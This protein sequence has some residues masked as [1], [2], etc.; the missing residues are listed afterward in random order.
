M[1]DTID[2]ANMGM[3]VPIVGQDPGPQWA[4]D[5][6]TC[7]GIIDAHTH[8]PGSGVQITPDGL[9]INTDLTFNSNNQLAIKSSRYTSQASPLGGGADLDCLYVVQGDL[10]YNDGAGN[11]VQITSGGAVAGTPGSISNLV[12]PASA[13]YNSGTGTFIW[14]SN[15]NVAANMDM[16][17]ITIREQVASANGITI[18]SPA[19]LGANYTLTLPAALPASVKFLTVDNAGNI[20]DVLYVDNSTIDI[21]SNNI[22]VAPSG[23]TATQLASNSVTT[24]KIADG[25]V[26]RPKLVSVG[27]Q[28]SAS[29]GLYQPFAYTGTYDQI[30]NLSC[31]ITTTGRPVFIGLQSEGN[32]SAGAYAAFGSPQTY[33]FRVSR[34]STVIGQFVIQNVFES[35]VR[36]TF[37]QLPGFLKLDN[38][39]AGTYTYTLK[40]FTALNNS[41]F[42]E[43]NEYQLV[44]YEL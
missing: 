14:E 22:R 19:S 40:Q 21:N 26:T 2:S 25:N 10:Y 9:N 30:T 24:A 5:V 36:T 6:N 41:Q 23:I 43:L 37:I 44:V 17:S 39:S 38:P 29:C 27:Q 18:S 32:A 34:D 8:S 3:P 1:A 16:A 31:T 35:G 20:G 11:Q 4:A 7:L 15:T 42:M 12:A 13:S 33:I 28:I